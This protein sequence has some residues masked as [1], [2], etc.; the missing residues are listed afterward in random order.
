MKRL[1]IATQL[2]PEAASQVAELVQTLKASLSEYSS[3][4]IK[5][6]SPSNLHLTLKFL[7]SV[8]ESRIPDIEWALAKSAQK[9]SAFLIRPKS[10]GVFLRRDSQVLWAGLQDDE[11]RFQN[12]MGEV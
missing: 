6:I 1:F 10:I 3:A 2:S 9:M 7:G 8:E 4:Q 11:K 5:W 12:L